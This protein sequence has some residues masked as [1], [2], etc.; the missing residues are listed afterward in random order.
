MRGNEKRCTSRSYLALG[1]A[2]LISSLLVGAAEVGAQAEAGAQEYRDLLAEADA[3]SKQG[4]LEEAA[5][6]FLK[7][8][9]IGGEGSV[10]ALLGMGAI[11]YRM[12]RYEKAVQTANRILESTKDRASRVAGYN[13]L[14]ISLYQDGSVSRQKLLEAEQALRQA[15]NL[16]GS[17]GAIASRYTLARL[18]RALDREGEALALAEDVI[19]LA[20]DKPLGD[21]ARVLLCELR[22]DVEYAEKQAAPVPDWVEENDDVASQVAAAYPR[23]ESPMVIG[24]DVQKPVKVHAPAPVYTQEARLAR[25]QG[26]V[27]IQAIIDRQGCVAQTKILKG[28]PEGLNENA[29]QAVSRWVFR[30]AT[31]DG[32]PVD[33]YYNLTVNFRLQKKKK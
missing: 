30:P 27:I 33:V 20:P 18:L 32:N 7:A 10:P 26:V 5:E 12:A 28:L 1:V 22:R 25:I 19:R 16:D 2:L 13:L 21:Q 8:S 11:Y 23:P 15:I 14:G 24:N 3:L 9:R 17:G 4:R 31:L 29:Q 6:A